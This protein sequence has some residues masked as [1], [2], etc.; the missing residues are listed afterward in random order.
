MPPKKKLSLDDL[1]EDDEPVV[2]VEK[3]AKQKPAKAPQPK[4]AP[5]P[6]KPP[7]EREKY[8][9]DPSDAGTDDYNWSLEDSSSDTAKALEAFMGKG[10]LRKQSELTEKQIVACALLLETAGKYKLP[11]IRSAVH[12]FLALRVSKDR[13]SR[14][15]AV[16]AFTGL[17][18]NRKM[19]QQSEFANSLR[20][21]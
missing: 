18:E 7:R 14:Q 2:V 8:E 20:R 4:P 15:E 12:H 5:K 6:V 3:E 11:R 1:L 10:D 21:D 19:N 16:N 9:N 13:G 17:V